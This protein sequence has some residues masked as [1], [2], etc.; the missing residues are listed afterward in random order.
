MATTRTTPGR[1]RRVL[2]HL[3]CRLR[4]AADRCVRARPLGGHPRPEDGAGPL[5]AVDGRIDVPVALLPTYSAIGIW[6]PILLVALRLIQGFAVGGEIS[7]RQRDDPGTLTV[8][9]PR[10]LRQL[11]PAG[12]AGRPDHRRRRLPAAVRDHVARKPSSPG[13]GASRS[14]SARWWSS[15]VTSFAAGWTRPP[16]SRRRPS[17]ARCRGPD[18]MAVRENGTDMLRVVCMAL[19]NAIPTAVT[20]FGATYA[21]QRRLRHRTD[22]HELSV[23]LGVRQHCRGDPDP[24]RRQSDGQDRPSTGDDRRCLGSGIL[25]YPYLYF[26]SQGNL[27]WRSCSRS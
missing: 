1:H 11:H 3:R 15:P 8:R 14:C 21:D 23:D 17:T 10:L 22:H 7:G 5:H 27:P 18:R 20:V 16:H 4:R 19:M 25:A 12:R 9:P 2:R 6:A 13:A 24:V 26:V